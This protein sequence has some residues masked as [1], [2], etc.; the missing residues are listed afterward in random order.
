MTSEKP[1]DFAGLTPKQEKAL[2]ELE[3]ALK[4]LDC[5]NGCAVEEIEA[6]EY[7]PAV[8]A[9]VD[10]AIGR[11]VRAGLA[12]HPLVSEWLAVCR[13]TGQ[14]DLLR[15]YEKGQETGV[16]RPLKLQDVWLAVELRDIIETR[17]CDESDAMNLRRAL[18]ARLRKLARTAEPNSMRKSQPGGCEWSRSAAAPWC[19]P[20]MCTPGL[21]ALRSTNRPTVVTCLR[22]EGHEMARNNDGPAG[23]SGAKRKSVHPGNDSCSNNNLQTDTAQALHKRP[24]KQPPPVP[25]KPEPW[26]EPVDIAALLDDAAS[27]PTQFRCPPARSAAPGW[28]RRRTW[29]ACRTRRPTRHLPRGS[30]RRRTSC[31]D[32]PD[33][34]RCW[35]DR[36]R[37]SHELPRRAM[38]PSH[39]SRPGR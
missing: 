14:K 29:Y 35:T 38:P 39:Q 11:A 30:A 33:I 22:Q 26:P 28:R 7:F 18:I 25:L 5:Y 27:A 1:D 6:V 20:K 23:Q 8:L 10:Q 17:G 21:S 24:Q 31:P 2:D 3:D 19:G 16:H 37:R 34:Q 36:L 12:A 15:K 4:R 32:L 13:A 9:D